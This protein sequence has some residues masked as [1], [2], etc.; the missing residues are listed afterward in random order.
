[1]ALAAHAAD[2]SATE[3]SIAD[4]T[5]QEN[6]DGDD[7]L[8][9]RDQPSPRVSSSA[10]ITKKKGRTLREGAANRPGN[11]R[12]TG[13]VGSGSDSTAFGATAAPCQG[14]STAPAA[15]AAAVTVGGI[16]RQESGSPE[17]GRGHLGDDTTSGP[18]EEGRKAAKIRAQ[19]S[20]LMVGLFEIIR[21][22]NARNAA[23]FVEGNRSR[24]GYAIPGWSPHV[25]HSMKFHTPSQ[26]LRHTRRNTSP[27]S[28][29]SFPSSRRDCSPPKHP[30]FLHR[31][32]F[33]EN[34]RATCSLAGLHS[35][36]KTI[37]R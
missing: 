17:A 26:R 12:E 14:T 34:L 33:A 29:V 27:F 31:A 13:G 37:T 15:T 1:M 5:K 30:P 32:L 21:Q 19:M 22:V 16:E 11:F 4:N 6:R 3:G 7:D 28:A 9:L 23:V 2:N 10:G 20:V 18:A 8:Y 25:L 36:S 24:W 35:R